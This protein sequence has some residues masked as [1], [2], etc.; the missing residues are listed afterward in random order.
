MAVTH[1]V[2]PRE[3]SDVVLMLLPRKLP[4]NAWMPFPT[5]SGP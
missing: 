2:S 4:I 5:F 3:N 1:G